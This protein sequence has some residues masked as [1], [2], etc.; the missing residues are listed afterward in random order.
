MLLSAAGVA[1][2][3]YLIKPAVDKVFVSRDI[4]ALYMIPLK[5][6]LTALITCLSTYIETLIMT[7]TSSKILAGL[8]LELFSKLLH[9][10]ID[11]YQKQSPSRIGAYLEDANGVNRL[12]SIV[13]SDFLLQFFTV[14]A[15]VAVMIYQNPILSIVSLVAL[16]LVIFPLISVGKKVKNL[17]DS[18]REKLSNVSS[19][20]AETFNNIR[21]IKSNGGESDEIDRTS[22]ILEKLRRTVISLAKKSLL[23]SPLM[24]MVSMLAFALVILYSGNSIVNGEIS[25]GDFFTFVIAMFSAYKPAKSL[26]NLNVEF[27]SALACARRYFTVLDQENM[28]KESANPIILGK[29]IG[30][31]EFCEVEFYYPDSSLVHGIYNAKKYDGEM[32]GQYAL[33]GINLSIKAGKSYALVGPSGSGKSTIFNL[34]LRFYDVTTGR[35]TIDGVNIMDLGFKNLR[36]NVS[37]V[38]QDVRLF[39]T[40]ILENIRY[41]KKGASLEEVLAVAEMA[42]VS[43]FARTMPNGYDTIVGHD[44]ALLSGGQKQRISIARAFLKNAPILLLDE[45]T[46]SLDPVSEELIQKSLKTLMEGK[47]TIIIAHR[48][49]TIINCDHIFVLEKGKLMEEGSHSE[50]ISI[51]GVYSNFCSKQFHFEK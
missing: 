42:N 49:S 16:P 28:V 48:L 36:S 12:I 26:T 22:S 50:L 14:I 35:I 32:T 21:V 15:L 40:S 37:I 1:Y 45:A 39:D 29:I 23:V 25:A 47:T 51:G 13:L 27:Q 31:L 9:R 6:T 19:S 24:E 18:E 2:R 30:N 46:S 10:D 11:F 43:E 3:A 8:Q 44:G 33:E 7:D 17:A 38:G 4:V 5:L 20:I 41:T 34:I